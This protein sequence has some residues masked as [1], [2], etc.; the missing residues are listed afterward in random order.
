MDLTLEFLRHHLEI[1]NLFQTVVAMFACVYSPESMSSDQREFE[2]L[3]HASMTGS[4]IS[5]I[6]EENE[7][8]DLKTR[9]IKL[10]EKYKLLS[11]QKVCRSLWH[12]IR[13]IMWATVIGCS[14]HGPLL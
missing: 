14:M 10:D 8:D 5:D 1:Y 12:V 2:E 3:S 9:C 11:E 13:C 7:D 4:M 6:F